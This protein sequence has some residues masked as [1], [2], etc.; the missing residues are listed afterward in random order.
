MATADA[1]SSYQIAAYYFPNYHVDRRNAAA[2]GPGWTEWE[3]VKQATPRFAG[4]Q[5]P[6]IPLWGYEDEADP[7]VFARKIDVA[8]DH[9]VD[10]FIFDWYWYDDGQF[11]QRALEDGYLHAPNNQRL[12]F[13]LMWANHNWV[14]IFPAALETPP[15]LLYGGAVTRDTFE[16]L[17]DYIVGAYFVHPSY[18]KIDGCP[19]FSV[20]ELYRLIEG[21]GGVQATKDA[22][23]SFRRKT[24][25][26]GFPD[27]HLNAVVWGLRILPGE[28]ML[29]NPAKMVRTLGIDSTTSYVWIHHV[30]LQEFPLTDYAAVMEQAVKHWD[31]TAATF[32][33]PYYPNVTVGWDSSPRTLQQ[34]PFVNA[35][36]P[37]TPT[38][39]SNTPDVFRSAL[40]ASKAFLDQP[41]GRSKIL[42][43]NSW[44]E[45]TEGSYL[46]P[47]TVH[48]LEYLQAIR[49]VFGR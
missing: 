38:L 39:A 48:G 33:V 15:A 30:P 4:H 25:A 49:D 3:L 11:L 13:A 9:G 24:V 26:A 37:Y 31:A 6:K 28:Q 29:A 42:T 46:E 40:Q 5:Q 23:D 32:D 34:G 41:A 45:W 8:A 1:L 10:C 18:W 2:L 14:D 16:R 12:R 22:L 21:L 19:Y 47:D 17:T 36:Y 7:A 20:Y 27:L 35:G 44:N 43:I